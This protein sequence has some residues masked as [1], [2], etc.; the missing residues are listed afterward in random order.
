MWISTII[1]I[2]I[3]L[4]FA[5][6]ALA[7]LVGALRHRYRALL[8]DTL[9]CLLISVSFAARAFTWSWS[10]MLLALGLIMVAMFRVAEARTMEQR[11]INTRNLLL[12][13]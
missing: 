4:V 12:L 11:G 6:V 13:R 1:N 9:G 7:S 10:P 8:V 2:G 5:W 3:A